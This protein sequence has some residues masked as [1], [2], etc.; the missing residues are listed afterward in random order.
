MRRAIS[1]VFIFSCALN[2][3]AQQEV[4][5][6]FQRTVTIPV[7]RS[8]KLSNSFGNVAVR[9]QSGRSAAIRASIECS[10]DST[11]AAQMICDDIQIVVQEGNDGVTVSTGLP[12]NT[13]GRNIGFRV[14]YDIALPEDAP[15]NVL[16]RFG[17]V[18]LTDVLGDAAVRN[19]NGNVRMIDG[20]GDRD[21]DN[22]FGNVELR[23]QQGKIKMTN[24]NGNVTVDNNTG[25]V[26][27]DIRF[28]DVAVT[29]NGGNVTISSS[30]GSIAA[31]KITGEV[32]VTHSF[33][34]VSV[35]GVGGGATVQN[36]NGAIALDDVSNAITA[37]SSFQG[38]TITNASGPITVENQNAPI[39]L[40]ARASR[41]CQDILLRTSFAPMRVRV[42]AEI[43]YM[44]T[45]KTTFGKVNTDFQVQDSQSR[46]NTPNRGP[47]DSSVVG[48]IPG[49]GS[50]NL[51]L[52]NQNGNIDITRGN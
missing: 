3:F 52:T 41:R 17:D 40:E 33:G 49:N 38:I 22:M 2:A 23:S 34:S 29:N 14:S 45:A 12:Q 39:T 16:N 32:S 11:A 9:S 50:C 31:S 46:T 27:A 13:G 35:K 21:I 19:A 51:I 10:A 8:F 25:A 15:L 18:T 48:R 37:R 24:T 43:G 44:L 1:L 5:R 30:T 7:G 42:P 20:R 47:Q 28:G 6:D 4:K 26:R 36:R